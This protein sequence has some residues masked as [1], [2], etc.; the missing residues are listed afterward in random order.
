M[1][2]ISLI[3]ILICSLAVL[4]ASSS[5]SQELLRLANSGDAEAQYTIGECYYRERGVKQ[6]YL[7]A[8]KWFRR[9][10]NQGHAKA[11]HDLA[12][13]Y[14]KGIRLEKN[15]DE[16]RVL[17]Q[18]AANQDHKE[19]QVVLG[20]IYK[21]GKGVAKDNVQAA[22]W[23]KKAAEQGHYD[24]MINLGLLYAEGEGITQD[25][26][27]AV[28]W[29]RVASTPRDLFD[30][31][32]NSNFELPAK[33]PE[34]RYDRNDATK[35]LRRKFTTDFSSFLFPSD[36]PSLFDDDTGLISLFDSY[37]VPLSDNTPF[38]EVYPNWIKEAADLGDSNAQMIM[39]Y[40]Y[41]KGVGTKRDEKEASKWIRKAAESGDAF[42]QYLTGR[43]YYEGK[44]LVQNYN[45][46][47][48]WL[49]K[50]AEQGYDY[51]LSQLGATYE[52]LGDYET[53]YFWYLLAAADWHGYSKKRDEMAK[54]LDQSQISEIQARAS[55]WFDEHQ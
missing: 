27:E 26:T 2:K 43:M 41:M 38:F 22:Q 9:A 45:E 40:F 21:T 5:F 30:I 50:A 36:L 11:Q 37:S 12:M 35:C 52:K 44:Y 15:Y 51:A 20:N 8:A 47:A 6:D 29:F 34:Q 3:L 14:Y 33:D 19:A 31:V 28:Y 48:Q 7:E 10:A 24:A 18:K 23:Y 53:A 1:K 49:S 25:F 55:K 39:S 32:N 4:M 17:L 54:K 42:A 13:M 16:A 46:A